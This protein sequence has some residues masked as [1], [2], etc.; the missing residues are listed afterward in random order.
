MSRA[1]RPWPAGAFQQALDGLQQ[2]RDERGLCERAAPARGQGVERGKDFR[3]GFTAGAGQAGL[4]GAGRLGAAAVVLDESDADLPLL[5]EQVQ[6]GG[7]ARPGGLVPAIGRDEERLALPQPQGAGAVLAFHLDLFAAR[8][9]Q[10]QPGEGH[11]K[12]HW[13]GA[14]PACR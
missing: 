11:G 5:K 4:A 13:R 7:A 10:R 8:Q 9:G 14:A 1:L 2:R 6:R 12:G 3:H